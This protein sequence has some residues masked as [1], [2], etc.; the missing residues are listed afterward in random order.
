MPRM[1]VHFVENGPH[2]TDCVWSTATN[3]PALD[4]AVG[5]RRSGIIGVTIR[6]TEGLA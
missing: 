6:K 4:P 2:A 3:V 1:A 5:D